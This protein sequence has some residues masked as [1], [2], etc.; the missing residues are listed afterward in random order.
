MIL[1][2]DY[3]YNSLKFNN[4][5]RAKYKKQNII[6]MLPVILKTVHKRWFSFRKLS[7]I[8]SFVVRRRN[9]VSMSLMKV[10]H[11]CFIFITYCVLSI[12]RFEYIFL[13]REIIFTGLCCSD[14]GNILI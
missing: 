1:K 11:L 8:K 3:V 14:M 10:R 6:D 4:S 13:Y 2:I 12:L 7:D 5:T 9:K